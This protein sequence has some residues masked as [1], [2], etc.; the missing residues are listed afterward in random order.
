MEA[1]LVLAVI[2]GISTGALPPGRKWT[3]LRSVF[4]KRLWAGL[5]YHPR[6]IL[7]QAS[8]QGRVRERSGQEIGQLPL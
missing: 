4:M 7:E 1:L 2:K 5:P 3:A 8:W 6:L